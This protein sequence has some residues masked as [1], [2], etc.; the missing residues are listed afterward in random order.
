MLLMILC[1]MLAAVLLRLLPRWRVLSLGLLLIAGLAGLVL[2]VRPPNLVTGLVPAFPVLIAVIFLRRDDLR[3]PLVQRLVGVVAIGT[4]GI[5]A[6]IYSD[7][8]STQWG[9]R[10]FHVLLPALVPLVVVG[11]DRARARC[12]SGEAVVAGVCLVVVALSLSVT[13]L[14]ANVA[15]REHFELL[16]G[17][18][19]QALAEGPD[20]SQ[21]LVIYGPLATDGLSRG[22]WDERT[23]MDVLSQV[24]PG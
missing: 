23:T 21:Q 18:T 14:R 20:A 6:T 15:Y 8:G 11:L 22:F 4:V 3:R 5:L 1:L 17:A 19:E 12:T 24:T 10:F 9:G 13:A 7:G 16:V 2:L